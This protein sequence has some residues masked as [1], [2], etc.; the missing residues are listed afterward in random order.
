MNLSWTPAAS[1]GPVQRHLVDAGTASGVYNIGSIAING[2]A[3]AAV[4][5]GVP[6]GTYFVRVRA[7]NAAATSAPSNER[8]VNVGS[9]SLPGPPGA[10]VASTNGTSVNLAWSAA[11]SG[12]VQGY[13]L[14]VGSA[15]G[16]ANLLVQDFP[17]SVTALGATG[18]AFGTYFARV[19]A[20]NVCGVSPPSNEVTVVVQ[21]CSGPPQAP[22][23]LHFNRTGSFVALGW[24]A[25]AAGPPPATYTLVV[26]S[27]P[28]GSDV[29]VVSTGSAT[30][31][32]AL[33]P[34]G[35]YFVRVI[36]QNACGGS[37]PSNEIDVLVP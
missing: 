10:L 28:G 25:P 30:S 34:P 1:G 15:P 3:P 27:V 33:A 7:Q 18:V 20:T 35:R 16:L 13:R 11:T 37:L 19:A 6:P 9:C 22:T 31:T 4:F 32:G 12:V 21:P 14:I 2:S 23:G 24:T 8:Q 29:L 26:G 36:A 17:S 5:N